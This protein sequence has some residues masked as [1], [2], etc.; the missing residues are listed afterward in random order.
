MSFM[1]AR[2]QEFSSIDSEF[3]RDN[4]LVQDLSVTSP[5]VWPLCSRH[6]CGLTEE[7]DLFELE[8]PSASNKDQSGTKLVFLVCDEFSEQAVEV[9]GIKSALQRQIGLTN[10][11]VRN[12]MSNSDSEEDD[13]DED[14]EDDDYDDEDDEGERP[15]RGSK[16]EKKPSSCVIV[17]IDT[18]VCRHREGF[19]LQIL[20][21][22]I[23]L[24]GQDFSG[25]L[26]GLYTLTQMLITQYNGKF[27][28][29]LPPSGPQSPK[30]QP[31]PTPLPTTPSGNRL[32]QLTSQLLSVFPSQDI[33][34]RAVMWS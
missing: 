16:N 25:L 12:A 11:S 2:W 8:I 32:V 26:Y 4:N 13:E 14:D 31:V 19:E 20:R 28:V 27:I 6:R 33:H 7:D 5:T 10:I 34:I 22:Q 9:S 3:Y 30:P 1:S 18:E 17:A 29:P 21:K 15:P 24:V 23:F